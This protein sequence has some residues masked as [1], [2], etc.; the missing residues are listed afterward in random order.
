MLLRSLA[1]S[2]KSISLQ[3]LLQKGRYLFCSVHSTDFLQLGQSTAVVFV[4]I[5]C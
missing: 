1:H 5:V 2:P 3:R 4:F